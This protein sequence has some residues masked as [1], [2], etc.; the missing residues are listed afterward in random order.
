AY[1]NP[2]DPADAVLIPA[3]S[4]DA[5]LIPF[6]I[7]PFQ[8]IALHL[9]LVALGYAKRG[10][11]ARRPLA[12]ETRD[13]PTHL[14]L[15]LNPTQPIPPLPLTPSGPRPPP[16][17]PPP[18]PRP[19]PPPQATPPAP[20]PPPAALLPYALHKSLVRRGRYDLILDK[21]NLTLTPPPRLKSLPRE[22]PYADIES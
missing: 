16:A 6:A 11:H 21:T 8:A 19:L 9:L 14:P 7:A 15:R 1:Y 3:F 10:P 4:P 17:P 13:D 22:I 2:A 18:T 5:V 20:P 12:L